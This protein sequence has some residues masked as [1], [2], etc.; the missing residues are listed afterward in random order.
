MSRV[1]DL[2]YLDQG[3]GEM[4]LL[5]N[6]WP[7]DRFLWRR[8]TPMLSLRFR[9]IVPDLVSGT[10]RDQTASVR[11]LL[12]HLEAERYAV[13]A[14]SHGG[15]VAQSLALDGPQPAA[16]ILVDTVAFDHEPPRDLEPLEFIRRGSVEFGS[17]TEHELS[18]YLN[19]PRR[20]PPDLDGAL[21]GRESEMAR[22]EFPVMLL[23]G[24]QDRHVP[25]AVAE[26]LNEIIPTSTLGVV[27]DSAHFLLDDAF[28]SV[29]ALMSEYLRARYL[30]APHG[31]E[32][33]VQLQLERRGFTGGGAE[34]DPRVPAPEDQEV[35]PNA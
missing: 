13:I 32:G 10:V 20:P 1:A 19:A 18:G 3:L 25:L 11:A 14:H 33:I 30:G 4:V 6:G 23:W 2:E 24:E 21:A 27:P 29:G 15:A 7:T 31:H 9:T 34:E 12:E 16:M 22:W 28:E 26:K 35:G 17:L 8:L 5:L